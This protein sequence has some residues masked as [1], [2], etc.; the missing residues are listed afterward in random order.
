MRFSRSD[1]GVECGQFVEIELETPEE[2][3]SLLLAI[4]AGMTRLLTTEAS[5]PLYAA[6]VLLNAFEVVVDGETMFYEPEACTIIADVLDGLSS[7]ADPQPDEHVVAFVE[8]LRHHA[9]LA[10]I[11]FM[12]PDDLSHLLGEPGQGS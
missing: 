11:G 6:R 5:V 4:E 9:Q 7:G 1:S 12:V 8:G 2:A 10:D 3:G